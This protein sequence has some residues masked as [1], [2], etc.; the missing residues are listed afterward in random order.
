M[1]A[2]SADGCIFVW[3]YESFKAAGTCT[4]VFYFVYA[5]AFLDPYPFLLSLDSAPSLTFWHVFVSQAFLYYQPLYRIDL[6]G[7][8]SHFT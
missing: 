6:V 3:D 7:T 5:L 1:L 2:T 8:G 4:N